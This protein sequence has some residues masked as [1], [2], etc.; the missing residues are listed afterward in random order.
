MKR[1]RSISSTSCTVWHL[2]HP[3]VSEKIVTLKSFCHACPPNTNHYKDSHFSCKSN[4]MFQGCKNMVVSA[5]IF[6]VSRSCSLTSKA[7]IH[8]RSTHHTMSQAFSALHW[9]KGQ[10]TWQH[11]KDLKFKKRRS[12][13]V[14]IATT[15]LQNVQK[16]I[17]TYFLR[18][19]ANSHLS[20]G[21]PSTPYF[22]DVYKHLW[23]LKLW[24]HQNLVRSLVGAL[25]PVA[26]GY[27]RAGWHQTSSVP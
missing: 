26:R 1:S 6:C 25:S 12:T 19:Q 14:S 23:R 17:F 21:S 10:P 3:M 4:L 20:M 27:I 9:Q 8:G 18:F 11:L 16:E 7:N 15:T 5:A 2:S 24:W 22:I 13:C